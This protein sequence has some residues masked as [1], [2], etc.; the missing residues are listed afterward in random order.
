MEENRLQSLMEENENKQ[1][2]ITI[3]SP[4]PFDQFKDN[5]IDRQISNIFGEPPI[6]FKCR[7]GNKLEELL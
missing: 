7:K 4:E 2:F 3:E 1:S 5:S 6:K